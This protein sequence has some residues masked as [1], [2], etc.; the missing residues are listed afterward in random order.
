MKKSQAELKARAVKIIEILRTA[1]QGMEKPASVQIVERFGRKPFL[2][3][4]SCLL[5]LRTRDSISFPASCRLFAQATTPQAMLK[6]PLIAI[7]KLIYSV[8]FYRNKARLLHLVSRDLLDRFEGKVPNNKQA[9]LSIKGIGLKTANLVLG[10]A[11][12]IPALC[13]DTHVHQISNRLGLVK[14]RTPEQTEQALQKII[15]KKH[16]VEYGYLM[17]MWGQ[18][19]CVPISPKCSLCAIAPLCPRIG[20]TRSR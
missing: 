13:V 14:T 5:S 19:I 17:V 1:T 15:P 11:F 16:W 10:A 6:L 18:N 7:Q 4:I 8:G 20:V 12:G 3:L 9:L 2:I